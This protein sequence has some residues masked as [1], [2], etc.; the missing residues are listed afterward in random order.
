MKIVYISNS[1]IPSFTANSIQAM[2]MCQALVQKGLDIELLSARR[3][4]EPEL[5]QV[6]LL[7][8]YGIRSRFPIRRI[9]CRGRIGEYIYS[10]LAVR[11]A[12]AARADIIYSRDLRAAAI[13]AR[14]GKPVICE[15]HQMPSGRLSPWYLKLFL[16]SPRNT[17]TLVT[18]TEHLKQD[19]LS[20]YR[21][22]IRNHPILVA[23]DGIDLE[24]FDDI[25]EIDHARKTLGL[26]QQK[27]IAGYAGHFYPGKGMEL[28]QSLARLC[29]DVH[30]LVMGG[31]PKEVASLRAQFDRDGLKNI[32]L[33]GFIPNADLPLHLAACDVLLLPTQQS[34]SGSSGGDISRWTSPLKLFEYM[35]SRRLIIASDMPVL[36]EVLNHANAVLCAPNDPDSWRQALVNASKNPEEGQA[37]IN[38]AYETVQRHTW[39]LRADMCIRPLT[40]VIQ[41]AGT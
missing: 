12:I 2:K 5:R 32:V 38:C 31:H 11:Q 1:T 40:D 14:I 35:A 18:I 27:F 4:V 34:V 8:H 29:P 36:R 28:I 25:P 21:D 6:D 16:S 26:K 3:Q 15:L 9:F 24:R 37:K 20:A 17:T 39:A 7:Q 23:P 13:I 19:L 33:R 10:L 30:F 22:L 41:R